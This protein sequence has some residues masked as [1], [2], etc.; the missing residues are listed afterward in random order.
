MAGPAAQQEPEQDFDEDD[1][2][3]RSLAEIAQ[4]REFQI[5]A[6]LGL[7][8]AVTALLTDSAYAWVVTFGY[9]MLGLP[10]LIFYFREKPRQEPDRSWRNAKLETDA[11]RAVRAK[12]QAFLIGRHAHSEEVER[13]VKQYEKVFLAYQGLLQR[14]RR[15]QSPE[16]LQGR[17]KV[18]EVV[19]RLGKSAHLFTQLATLDSSQ[20]VKRIQTLTSKANLSDYDRAELQS[21]RGKIEVR[22]SLLS[23]LIDH[24]RANDRLL[25]ELASLGRRAG[26]QD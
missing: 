18:E 11:D 12:L 2:E 13:A 26:H 5:P 10:G 22:D 14:V 4:M 15:A 9:L 19:G 8:V 25:V 3:T 24:L 1:V 7:A 21:L 20:L 6:G 23:D 17:K 16:V